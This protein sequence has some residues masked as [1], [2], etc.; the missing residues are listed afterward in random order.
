MR[1]GFHR[2]F[3][4][5]DFENALKLYSEMGVDEIDIQ[6][7][8]ARADVNADVRTAVAEAEKAGILI[9][10]IS[11][12]W[13]WI[14]R[15]IGDS[16]E[17]DRMIVFIQAAAKLGTE[18][19]MMSCS[20]LSPQSEEGKELHFRQV[21]GIYRKIAEA[22]EGAGVD[23]C[24]HTSSHRADIMFGTVDGIDA[25]LDAVGSDRNKLLLCCGCLSVAGWDVSA[26]IHHWRNAIGAV[27][28]FNPRGNREHYDEMRF[29]LG[30]LDLFGVLQSLAEVGYTGAIVSHEYPMF[31]GACGKEMS[32]SWVVGYLRAM[33][34]VI[35]HP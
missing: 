10:A 17:V 2:N 23:L 19:I 8:D 25:F 33:L 30:Q 20:F 18:R 22:A 35:E 29:D 27:H 6:M 15:A 16:S 7:S 32:D 26:L 24:T 28:F 21:V 9:K 3:P 31:S 34:Q 4:E 12:R 1:I 14:M 5:P 13:G 11:P